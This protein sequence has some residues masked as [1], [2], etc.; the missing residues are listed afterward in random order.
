MNIFDKIQEIIES[1]GLF[2][3]FNRYMFKGLVAPQIETFLR[4]KFNNIDYLEATDYRYNTGHIGS[5][6]HILDIIP[7][8]MNTYKTELFDCD[9]FAREYWYLA[10][11]MYPSLPV[12]YCHVIR[13]DGVKHAA[14]FIVYVT[15][16]GRLSMAFIEPQ[17]GK[18]SYYDWQPYMMLI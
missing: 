18:I 17:L 12:G 15:S 4:D 16:R 2:K 13:S 3:R 7:T 14:N 8:K 5:L 6:R 1:I 11:R 10:K 9:D